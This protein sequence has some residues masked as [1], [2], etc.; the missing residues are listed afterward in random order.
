[1]SREINKLMQSCS[2]FQVLKKIK[3]RC[4]KEKTQDRLIKYMMYYS[5]IM[6]SH[7]SSVSSLILCYEKI[8]EDLLPSSEWQYHSF[9]VNG[10]G[11]VLKKLVSYYQV[12]WKSFTWMYNENFTVWN[13]FRKADE[14]HCFFSSVSISLKWNSTFVKCV[15]CSTNWY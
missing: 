7:N 15:D 12:R 2:L 9:L 11:N 3:K 14:F 8:W 1:M 4:G 13:S 6:F 10:R 5:N